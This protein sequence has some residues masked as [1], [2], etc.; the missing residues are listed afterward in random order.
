MT[1]RNRLSA[2]VLAMA[3]AVVTPASA[4]TYFVYTQAGLQQQTSYFQWCLEGEPNCVAGEQVLCANPEGGT[5]QEHSAQWNA[6]TLGN[7]GYVGWGVFPWMPLDMRDYAWIDEDSNGVPETVGNLRV[8]VKLDPVPGNHN[9][10][11]EIECNPD[12]G[13]YPAG[14]SYS[15][16]ITDHGWQPNTSWQEVVVPLEDASFS[17]FDLSTNPFTP[18]VRPLD[19]ACLS[20]VKALFKATLETVDI[21]TLFA[22]MSIDFVRWELPKPQSGASDIEIQGRNLLVD[23]RPFVIN[24]VA[25]APVGIGENWQSAWRDRPDRY[26]VDFPLMADMGV[27]TVRLYAPVVT[28]AMLDAAAV[29][30]LYVIPTFGVDSINLECAEGKT[31][32]ADRFAQT[33]QEWK[34][35]P[36]ILAWLV[37]NEVNLNLT[38]GADLCADF[39]P[40]LDSMALAAQNA[41]SSQPVG[42]AMAGMVDV[43][44]ACADDTA[45]PNVDFWGTQLYRGC[46]YGTAFTEYD[47]KVD[48]NRPL[49]VT[50]YGVDAFN[51][52]GPAP[53]S[54]DQAM[55]ASCI[56]PALDEGHLELAARTP[57][58][59][60]A[61]QTLF[62]WQD[63]WW[64]AEC[65]PTTSWTVQDD[66]ASSDNG[67]FPDGKVHEEWF[68]LVGVVS[69]AGNENARPTRA[70]YDEIGDVWL[71]P[72]CNMQVDTFDRGTGDVTI[73]FNEAKGNLDPVLGHD[74]HYG[75]LTSVST[76]GYTG[77]IDL[78]A[79][80]P[81]TITL[82]AGDLFWIVA[83]ENTLS[84]D[85]CH[86]MD[87]AGAERPCSTGNCVSGWNCS[88]SRP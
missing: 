73:S 14:V 21:N 36:A 38:A 23:G 69:G 50:E 47:S 40:T 44:P 13:T 51:R 42:S 11:L 2:L 26:L 5:F 70:V 17:A 22:T 84:E 46:T 67:S 60:L 65:E 19:A 76:Y 30:G 7:D 10:K 29:E 72:V 6:D 37:G 59:V 83:G 3:A 74:L 32:L 88:C 31:F 9:I 82:P 16:F 41:G 49:I 18:I 57:G 25:Y 48:C 66:C 81:G 27:N 77:S 64:K 53:G 33:V 34:D 15:T 85:G 4:D 8:F 54:E 39:Y 62:E 80:S 24:G 86:G 28:N 35:H 61:G 52:P 87:G 71:G 79:T 20:T 78:G 1:R 43:C 58:G 55:Q 45:L 12:P 75:P 56:T 68:G 63:E